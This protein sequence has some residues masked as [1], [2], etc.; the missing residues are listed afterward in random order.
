MNIRTT[1]SGSSPLR[2]LSGYPETSL[3][4]AHQEAATLQLSKY[5]PDHLSRSAHPRGNLTLREGGRNTPPAVFLPRFGV[6]KLH[7]A[8]MGV[9]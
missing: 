9:T 1:Q 7:N 2:Q 6:K 8:V 3:S 4:I 5:L